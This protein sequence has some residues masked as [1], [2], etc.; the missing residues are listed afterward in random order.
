[1]LP[2]PHLREQGSPQEVQ[3]HVPQAFPE[4]G[5]VKQLL[6]DSSGNNPSTG[7]LRG[8]KD[9]APADGAHV[10]RSY[11]SRR[12]TRPPRVG[13][14]METVDPLTPEF[15]RIIAAKERRRRQ[16]A[17]LP[18]PVKVRLVVQ[19][20]QMAAPIMRARGRRVR[21]WQVDAGPSL[22]L[23]RPPR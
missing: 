14:Q 12:D 2:D 11:V 5:L 23:S 1:M 22:S 8:E 21:V 17:A 13:G 19:L 4:Q 20:Q 18:F 6:K 15:A 3:D 10:N 16:L 7:G 9:V